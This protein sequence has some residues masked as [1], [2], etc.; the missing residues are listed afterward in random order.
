MTTPDR[1][2]VLIRHS[3]PVVDPDR[4]ASEW[5][6]S[7]EGISRCRILASELE[8]FLPAVIFS[9]PEIKAAQTAEH[10]G[11]NLGLGFSVRDELREHR[12]PATFLPQS[13]FHEKIRGFFASRD[14]IVYGSESSND[15]AER[16]EAEIRRALADHPDGNILMVTHGT[17]MTS[18]TSRHTNADAYSLWQSL[19]LPAY[20][21]FAFPSFDIVDSAGI[22]L[23]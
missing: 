7:S 6:L 3:V 19:E 20:I 21:A 2:V 14:D 4:P 13:E 11:L 1:I 8:R 16:I 17:A 12:R 10:I 15:V 23:D 9:S 18:F 5:V 22:A